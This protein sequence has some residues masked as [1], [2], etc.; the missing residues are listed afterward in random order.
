MKLNIRT[1]INTLLI[2]ILIGV[3]SW[4]YSAVEKVEV[5]KTEQAV[6]KDKQDRLEADV[7]EVK[8][9]IKEIKEKQNRSAEEQTRML[10]QILEN[11]KKK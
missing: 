8:Q 10:Q 6:T 3:G 5:L 11:T 7:R 4:A 1:L 2:A 9:D